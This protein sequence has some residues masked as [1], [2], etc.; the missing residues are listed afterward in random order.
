MKVKVFKIDRNE[1]LKKL[2][3]WAEELSRNPDVM[4]VILFGSFAR[5]DATPMSDA[6]VLILLSDS[7]KSFKDRIS[8]FITGKV[9]VSVDVFP[10]TV[11]EFIS[12]VK[13][14]WGVGRIAIKEGF[15]LYA[16]DSVNGVP[17]NRWLEELKSGSDI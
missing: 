2:R 11:E 4:A 3:K 14:G 9:G 8:D 12:S 10:Y 17:F 16:K 15:I 13:E 5:N 7:K 1:I 6:D